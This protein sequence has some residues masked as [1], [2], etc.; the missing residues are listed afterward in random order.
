MTTII[1]EILKTALAECEQVAHA[2]EYVLHRS[3]SDLADTGITGYQARQMD[4]E[5]IPADISCSVTISRARREIQKLYEKAFKKNAEKAKAE[6]FPEYRAA[7]SVLDEAATKY[8]PDPES[9]FE[10]V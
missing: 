6:L 5:R 10:I 9:E 2:G 7:M 8:C 4:G 1:V 3:A